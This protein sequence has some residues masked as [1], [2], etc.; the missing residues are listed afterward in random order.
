MKKGTKPHNGFNPHR[1]PTPAPLRVL[2]RRVSAQYWKGLDLRNTKR[3]P[4]LELWFRA[5]EERPAYLA[6]KSDYYTHCQ[7]STLL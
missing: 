1:T 7:V 2:S 3:W 4:L 6:T 5:F